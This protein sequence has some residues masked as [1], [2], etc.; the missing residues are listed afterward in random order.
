MCDIVELGLELKN[1]LAAKLL[2]DSIQ[3][4]LELNHIDTYIVV[5]QIS[6]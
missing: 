3:N 5:N 4:A 6:S 2:I 1:F